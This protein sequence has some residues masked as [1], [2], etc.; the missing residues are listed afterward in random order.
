M[1]HVAQALCEDFFDRVA[2]AAAV[3]RAT[4]PPAGNGDA[5]QMGWTVRAGLEPAP[6]PGARLRIHL[7]LALTR[8]P[9]VCV[10]SQVPNNSGVAPGVRALHECGGIAVTWKMAARD[11]RPARARRRSPPLSPPKNAVTTVAY[12]KLYGSV[13]MSSMSR[14]CEQ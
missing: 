12:E 11:A 6:R 2:A 8:P 5:A 1:C 9:C 4:R 7:L 14:E 13:H 10:S 3:R